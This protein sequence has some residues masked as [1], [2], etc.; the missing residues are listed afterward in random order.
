MLA[1]LNHFTIQVEHG[2]QQVFNFEIMTPWKSRDKS[3]LRILRLY[4]G[5]CTATGL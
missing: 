1:P 5:D 3:F 4:M 2:K